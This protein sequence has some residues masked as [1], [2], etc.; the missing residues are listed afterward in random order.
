MTSESIIVVSCECHTNVIMAV[1]YCIYASLGRSNDLVL[2][3]NLNGF[4]QQLSMS[5]KKI[6]DL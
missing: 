3:I 5:Q 2:Q 6:I 1:F 4:E